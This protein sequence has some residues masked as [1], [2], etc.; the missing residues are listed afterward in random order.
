MDALL[1]RPWYTRS[2]M[3]SGGTGVPPVRLTGGTPVPPHSLCERVKEGFL[4]SSTGDERPS[5]R[6]STRSLASS[7]HLVPTLCVGTGLLSLCVAPGRCHVERGNK[8]ACDPGEKRMGDSRRWALSP[9][10][11]GSPEQLSAGLAKDRKLQF[12]QTP[13]PSD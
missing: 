4:P 3:L 13:K 5:I 6:F 10:D 1:S 9:R 2:L 7:R 12:N 11:F 8:V